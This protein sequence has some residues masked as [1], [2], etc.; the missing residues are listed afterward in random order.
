MTMK[1]THSTFTVV[2]CAMALSACSTAMVATSSVGNTLNQQGRSFSTNVSDQSITYKT[3]KAIYACP[4]LTKSSRIAVVTFERNVLLVG[5]TPSEALKQKAET[6]V[7]GIP[8]IRT[9]YNDISIREPLNNYEQ[10]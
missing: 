3:M 5:E 10:G 7:R 6:L 1:K 4:E 8:N 2:V 9:I